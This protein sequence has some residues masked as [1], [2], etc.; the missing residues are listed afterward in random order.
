[1]VPKIKK[2]AQ[3]YEFSFDTRASSPCNRVRSVHFSPRGRR[4]RIPGRNSLPRK[5]PTRAENP[6]QSPRRTPH[7][8]LCIF[9]AIFAV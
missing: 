1:M 7:P 6:Q 2:S 8:R 5:K 3:R 4:N 9:F